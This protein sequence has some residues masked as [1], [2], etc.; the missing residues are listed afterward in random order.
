MK[1]KPFLIFLGCLVMAGSLCAQQLT[2]K[3]GMITDSV[4]VGDS[5]P[6]SFSVYLPTRFNGQAAWPVLFVF[7]IDGKA[8]QA[9]AMFREAAEKAGFLLAASN[10]IRDS[11]S[12]SDNIL[13]TQRMINRVNA[14][15][16]LQHRRMYSAGR[17]QGAQLAALIPSFIKEVSGAISLGSGIP[18]AEILDSRYPFYFLGIVGVRDFNYP[19]MVDSKELLDRKDIPNNLFVFDGGEEWPDADLL[20]TAFELLNIRA[21]A[22][23]SMERDSAMAEGAYRQ[24]M[25]EAG[26]LKGSGQ[27][28]MAYNYLEEMRSVFA[29]IK[30]VDSIMAE[31]NLI[32]KDKAF[33]LQR[34][35]ENAQFFRENLKR[36]EFAYYLEEDIYTYNFDNLGWWVHQMELLEQQVAGADPAVRNMA[37]R[38]KGYLNALIE[39]YI[40]QVSIEKPVDE[41][42]L[43][44]L[45]MLKTITA[46]E[47]YGNYLKIISMSAKYEDYGTSLFY[48]EELLK[49][50][51]TD[52]GKLY[53]LENTALLRITPE[54]NEI[55]GNYLKSARY[56]TIED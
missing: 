40:D 4:A 10:D 51:Y 2:F 37:Q 16:P 52:K 6:E 55:I 8:R 32:K 33:R 17:A 1:Q 13:I 25:E 34:R 3:K 56:D 49:N 43:M 12:I 48:L 36:E 5:I 15:F 39:D 7:D 28:Y 29:G 14:L 26:R 11:L 24:M 27:L 23:G 54:Y 30:D 9:L 46:P 50:G 38:L 18:N 41:E 22:N 42:A 47:E 19:D 21:M 31:L 45:W 53:E 35:N 20:G 44:F